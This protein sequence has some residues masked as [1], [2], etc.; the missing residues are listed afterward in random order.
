MEARFEPN[1]IVA[2]LTD[3]GLVDPYVGQMKAVILALFPEARIVDLA[4]GVPPQDVTVGAFF[5]AR[6][7]A[8]FAPGTT[9][10]A[11]VDPG[12]GSERRLLVAEAGE[13]VFLAP[14]NGLLP[15][16][17]GST[18]RFRELDPERCS[19]SARS[20]TF[21]GRD[22]FAPAAAWLARGAPVDSVARELVSPAV[23]GALPTAELRGKDEVLARVLF[24]DHYGNLVL[25]ATPEDFDGEVRGWSAQVRGASIAFVGTYAE[26]RSGTA[27]ALVDS[28]GSIELAVRDGSA[29]A[30]LGLGRGDP[31]VFSRMHP[32]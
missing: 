2:L 29:A 10:V 11:V 32:C 25:G 12:V 3:F 17:L 6:S 21:H 5:L 13:H 4:H 27:C 31:V 28:F 24:A 22:V 20:R 23:S 8:Y 16:A 9:F 19:L 26:A 30:M 7:R 14:D 18:A 1:G 15:A